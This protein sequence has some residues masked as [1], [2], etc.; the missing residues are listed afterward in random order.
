MNSGKSGQQQAMYQELGQMT[1]SLHKSL[2][3][4]GDQTGLAQ[5]AGEIPSTRERLA[6]VL[7][8]TEQAV[9]RVLNAVDAL[10]PDI[11]AEGREAGELLADWERCADKPR[12]SADYSRLMDDTQVFLRACEARSEVARERLMDI[13]LA[14]EFQDLTGQVIKKVVDLAG[15]ME[16]RLL[17]LLQQAAPAGAPGATGKKKP[18]NGLLNGPAMPSDVSANQSVASQADVDRLLDELGF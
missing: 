11:E 13:V 5:A 16:S 15:E 17:A 2:I 10:S 4:L 6:Y 3:D 1:R 12:D 8:M 9:S 18:G 7:T 14:Q